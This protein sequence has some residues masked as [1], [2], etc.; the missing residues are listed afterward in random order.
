MLKKLMPFT[1][2]FFCAAG[3]K[4]GVEIPRGRKG[5][6]T[7]FSVRCDFFVTFEEEP[8]LRKTKSSEVSPTAHR[9][10]KQF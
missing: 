7:N 1:F 5:R 8:G 10:K 9:Q 4:D 6:T 2:L 3:R